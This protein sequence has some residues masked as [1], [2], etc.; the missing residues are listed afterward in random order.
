MKRNRWRYLAVAAVLLLAVTAASASRGPGRTTVDMISDDGFMIGSIDIWNNGKRLDGDGVDIG[1]KLIVQLDYRGEPWH[2][3][4]AKLYA[5]P[6]PVPTSA[7]GRPKFK[8]FDKECHFVPS[9]QHHTFTLDLEDDVGFSWGDRPRLIYV[10]LRV[11]LERYGE[12]GEIAEKQDVWAHAGDSAE[13]FGDGRWGYFFFYE[14]GHPKRGQLIDAPVKG[15][16]YFTPTHSGITGEPGGFQ[17]FPGET[18]DFQIDSFYVG[19][20]YAVPKVSPID[21]YIGSD[22]TSLD[23]IG[24]ARTLQTLDSDGETGGRS[25][26]IV[27]ETAACF[28]GIAAASRLRQ[29]DVR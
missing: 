5:S 4:K 11:E 21:M 1:S 29:H 22:T 23:V 25:I 14:I 2:I 3:T 7:N 12:N 16:S 9:T 8:T 13:A 17:Y 6:D 28:A 15:L 27:A 26:V 19:T 20:A 24:T 18:V 10:A